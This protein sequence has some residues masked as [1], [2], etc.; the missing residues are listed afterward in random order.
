MFGRAVHIRRSSDV[1]K[2][3]SYSGYFEADKPKNGIELRMPDDEETSS[4][5]NKGLDGPNGIPSSDVEYAMMGFAFGEYFDFGT[6]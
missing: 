2:S 1:H 6:R 4:C 3:C 5:N